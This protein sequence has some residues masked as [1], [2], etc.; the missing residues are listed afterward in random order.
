[1]KISSTLV[2]MRPELGALLK[3][4]RAQRALSLEAVSGDAKISQGYLHKLEAGRVNNPSPNVLQRLGAVLD[5]PYGQLMELSGYVMPEGRDAPVPPPP[6]TEAGP[7]PSFPEFFTQ[8]QAMRRELAELAEG[9][10][11][12]ARAVEQLRD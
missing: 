9:Q 2:N 10:Q 4:T 12:L 6:R 7:T 1:M 11:R 8:I 3:E 5:L